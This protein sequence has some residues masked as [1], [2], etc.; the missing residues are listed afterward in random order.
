MK[1]F[2]VYGDYDIIDGH[3]HIKLFGRLENGQSFV[4]LNR[5]PSYLFIREKDLKKANKILQ[6]YKTEKTELKTF[7]EEEVIRVLSA[8]NT[9]LNKL[10]HALH[11]SEINT[12]EADIKP[13][14]RFI[15]DNNIL[16]S[17]DIE[18]DYIVAERVDRFYHEPRITPAS[19]RPELKVVSIDLESSEKGDLFCIGIYS[20]N[21][22]KNFMVTDKKLENTV[23]C[24]NE[25]DCLEKFKAEIIKLDPDII[26]GWNIIEFD[27]VYLQDLYRKHKIPLDLGRTNTNIRIKIEEN[28][29]KP[30]KVDI[31]GRQVLDAMYMIRDPFIQEAPSIKNAKFESYTLENVSQ[32]ILGT[33]KLLKGKERHAEIEELYKK[34]QNK[35]V[36]YNLLDCKLAYDILKKTE[37]IELAVE[38]SHLTGMPLDKITASIVA[39]DS[40]YIREARKHSLVVPT[41][42]YGT[43]EDKIKGGYVYSANPGIYENVLVLDFKSLYPSIIRT[44]NI[45]PASFLEKKEKGCITTPNGAFFKNKEGILPTILE[46]L[47]EEREKAK[48]DKKELASYTIKIIMNSFYGVMASANSRYFKWDMANAIT[49]LAEFI[50]KLT[51]KE[52][53]KRGF[54]VIYQDTDSVFVQ[55]FQSKSKTEQTGRFL[56]EHINNFYKHYIKENYNRSSH[57]ELQFDKHF[58]SLMIPKIRGSEDGKAA[59]KRY[60]GL[61]EKNGKEELV[62]VGLEAIRGDWTEAAQDFQREILTR[63]FH[64][65]EI[66]KIIKDCLKKIKSGKMDSKLVYRKSIRKSLSEYTKTTPP[67][68]KA[69]RQLDKL[70]SNIIEYYITTHGPEPVQKLKH[71]L[72]YKHYI[73]KQIAP[74]ANQILSLFNKTF[75]D[76]VESSKQ[77]KLF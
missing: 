36:E 8:N 12:F 6:K 34:D 3:L 13:Y 77:T 15:I 42:R 72:D 50:I 51:A 74:I 53:E 49:H 43:K 25:A 11:S 35:L 30:S 69:A 47:H 5:V 70:D 2:I 56:E 27:L 61:I 24:K 65:E 33:G 64:K 17:L 37:I 26:T 4:T 23:P 75:D 40:L 45:D 31:P 9:E 44:F 18:G 29:F 19:T 58:L 21:Y 38:R 62:I 66:D 46:R 73:D 68:V 54:K 7:Q 55:T 22:K 71:P 60:A 48:K 52:I 14:Y 20:N 59:K 1:G 39:F 16:G 57:L 41:T 32:V 63:I 67:H 10:T 28:Y 76:T